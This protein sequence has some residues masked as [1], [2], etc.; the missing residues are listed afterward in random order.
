MRKKFRGWRKFRN[1]SRVLKFADEPF[2]NLFRDKIQPR[3]Q[4]IFAFRWSDSAEEY[5]LSQFRK[6]AV[7]CFQE[8]LHAI[9]NLENFSSS[10]SETNEHCND[11]IFWWSH[12]NAHG[13]D[14][15]ELKLKTLLQTQTRSFSEIVTRCILLNYSSALSDHRKAKMPRERGWIG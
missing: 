15:K 7:L 10:T 12:C 8:C 1:F 11:F 13:S 14:A 4:G 9:R 3:S 6:I 5:T 2:R